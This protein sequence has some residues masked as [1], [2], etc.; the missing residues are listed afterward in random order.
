VTV[1]CP[2]RDDLVAYALGAL[3]PKEQ[4]AVEAHA[5]GCERCTRELEALAP[6]VAVLGESVEQLEP[7]REL[8][9][10]V[11]ATVHAESQAARAPQ[12]AFAPPERRSVRRFAL[13]PAAGLAAL[14]VA[15][16]G[17]AGYLVHDQGSGG[18]STVPVTAQTGIGGSLAVGD[19]SSMLSLHGMPAL[20]KGD[21]Y[22]VWV[23][24][25]SYIRPSS[26]F[27][28]DRN[29]HAIT[30]VDGHLGSGTRVMVT[31]ESGPGAAT[32]SHP[33]LLSATV[34]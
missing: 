31:R 30:A 26:N 11:M 6:A 20:A 19:T 12:P 3:E 23:A 10:R 34:D 16:A 14:A 8:R 25:D 22:Q 15:G 4:R 9:Q 18:E 27:I 17:V 28:P 32:P 33:V 29:G 5:P 13:R 21:V 7:R 24:K 1:A 2:R